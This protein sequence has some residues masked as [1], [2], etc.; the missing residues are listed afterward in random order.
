MGQQ[1][2]W[3]PLRLVFENLS[4]EPEGRP[5]QQ[6]E[7][8]FASGNSL[9]AQGGAAR[10][11]WGQAGLPRRRGQPQRLRSLGG[12]G[13]AGTW[14]QQSADPCLAPTSGVPEASARPQFSGARPGSLPPWLSLTSRAAGRIWAS[15][16]STPGTVVFSQRT[17]ARKERGRDCVSQCAA[18]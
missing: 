8:R 15:A 10:P 2:L 17:Y 5:E 13:P 7:Q 6:N 9:G 16:H 11:A 18:E 12:A 3:V 14:Q 1:K 4:E